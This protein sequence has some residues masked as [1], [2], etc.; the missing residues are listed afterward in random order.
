MRIYIVKSEIMDDFPSRKYF[1]EIT[2]DEL[3]D[4]CEKND[5]SADV[6]DCYEQ[7]EHSWNIDD[8][9]YPIDTLIRFVE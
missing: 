1:D 4:W 8:I 5:Q 9:F 6:Y 7:F 2:N 3:A